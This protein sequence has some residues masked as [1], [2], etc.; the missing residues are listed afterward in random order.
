MFRTHKAADDGQQWSLSAG[1]RRC[2]RWWLLLFCVVASPSV[3]AQHE[4][5]HDDSGAAPRREQ[6]TQASLAKGPG[7]IAVGPARVALSDVEV[8][9]QDG[10]RLRFYSDLFKGRVVVVSVF[11]TSC[12]LV[13]PMQARV[14]TRLK[15]E[16]GPRLG[17]DVFFISISRDPETDTP[18][19]LKRWGAAYGVGPGWTLVTGKQ[20]V[21]NKLLL[22][23]TG[24]GPG[25]QLHSP[26]LLIGNDRTGVWTATDGLA[27]IA[28]LIKVI[29]KVSS[30]AQYEPAT[31]GARAS[32]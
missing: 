19:R 9:N 6:P 7:I 17:R 13:C 10:R 20:F 31:T 3:F 1:A 30:G 2:A 27:P 24:G 14:L 32:P 16:L 26:V 23:F 18:A 4:H 21:M 5:A 29:D 8:R 28:E 11:F 12:T 15:A 25:S 22:D